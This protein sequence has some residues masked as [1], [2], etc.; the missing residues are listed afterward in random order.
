L[1]ARRRIVAFEYLLD[2]KL[3]ALSIALVAQ[4][5]SLS[6]VA[7]E[8]QAVMGSLDAGFPGHLDCAPPLLP[9]RPWGHNAKVAAWFPAD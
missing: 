1:F 5:K 3:N 4:E 8:D 6:T 7:H 9:S 2:D